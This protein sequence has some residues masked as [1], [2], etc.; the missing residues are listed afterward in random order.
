[1][2]ELNGSQY[3]FQ[4]HGQIQLIITT[5]GGIEGNKEICKKHK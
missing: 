5:K 4:N 3:N 1:M 2:L